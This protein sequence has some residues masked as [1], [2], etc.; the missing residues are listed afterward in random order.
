M[1]MLIFKSCLPSSLPPPAP[2]HNFLFI[3][4]AN[5]ENLMNSDMVG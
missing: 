2:T 5:T 3:P 4:V 1:Y